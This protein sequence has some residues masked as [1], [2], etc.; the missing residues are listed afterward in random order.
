MINMMRFSYYGN[1]VEGESGDDVE[2][3]D[4]DEMRICVACAPSIFEPAELIKTQPGPSSHHH[5]D[6]DEISDDL[7]HH[8]LDD[9]YDHHHHHYVN[10]HHHH[11]G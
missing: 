6:L 4:D 8:D 10:I 3:A 7:Y 2:K 11:Q 5:H 1:N 9:G